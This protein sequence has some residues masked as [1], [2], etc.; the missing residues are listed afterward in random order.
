MSHLFFWLCGIVAWIGVIACFCA[1]WWSYGRPN[2]RRFYAAETIS[3][4]CAWL[5]F[6]FLVIASASELIG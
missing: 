5:A 3:E 2:R 1:M 4:W 6:S